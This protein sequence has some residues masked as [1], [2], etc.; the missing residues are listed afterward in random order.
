LKEAT[1][2]TMNTKKNKCLFASAV[3]I[4][5]FLPGTIDL[6]PRA[7][8]HAALR[9]AIQAPV[10]KW[11]HGGCTFWCETGWYSSPAVA[12]LDVVVLME[13][14]A[15]HQAEQAAGYP[16][17]C[18]LPS[19]RSRPPLEILLLPD[20]SEEIHQQSLHLLKVEVQWIARLVRNMLELGRYLLPNSEQC[21]TAPPFFSA[22]ISASRL[23]ALTI[24][25]II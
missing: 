20:I 23:S 14:P 18:A 19:G 13:V 17:N 21:S 6:A 11:Q 25:G 16:T 10:L 24:C 3:L 4:V 12:D 5:A 22:A 8:T 2:L 15:Q 7:V 9:Q 1:I